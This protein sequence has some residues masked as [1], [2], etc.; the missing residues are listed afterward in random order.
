MITQFTFALALLALGTLQ[1]F[2]VGMDSDRMT[3]AST[4]VGYLSG[5]IVLFIS[6]LLI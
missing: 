4:V 6:A 3:I 2:C 1:L 5:F